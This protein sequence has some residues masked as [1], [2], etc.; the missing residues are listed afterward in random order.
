ML[1]H[2]Y[3]I[4]LRVLL[5]LQVKQLNCFIECGDLSEGGKYGGTI[6]PLS[7][8]FNKRFFK[9]HKKGYTNREDE[10]PSLM[11]KPATGISVVGHEGAMLPSQMEMTFDK[12]CKFDCYTITNLAFMDLGYMMSNPPNL[13]G[14][15]K[16]FFH[17]RV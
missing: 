14:I 11:E 16:I 13:F 10:W 1:H 8:Y 3:Y 12:R 9:F 6:Q 4:I 15:I 17:V 2:E 5:F 7:R